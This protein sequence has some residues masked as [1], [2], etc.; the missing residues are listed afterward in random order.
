MKMAQL[1][2]EKPL[3]E[4]F[5]RLTTSHAELTGNGPLTAKKYRKGQTIF[6]QGSIPK[7]AHYIKSGW[8]KISRVDGNGNE[9]VLR[10]VTKNQFIGHLSLIKKWDYLSTAVAVTDCEIFF[11]AKQVFF[12]LLQKDNT[13][14]SLVI[15]M[16]AD[17]LVETETH[18]DTLLTK[19]IQERI[20][21][22][23]LSLEQS[24]DAD[25][26]FNDS[27]I[28]LPKKDLAAIVNITPETLSRHLK[29]LDDEGL[30]DNN[31]NHIELLNRNEL[32]K[33]SN[34]VD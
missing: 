26:T 8:V 3:K 31:K 34:L 1:K 25:P 15:E 33:K 12:E 28:R 10:L 19:N 18:L 17:E 29:M 2:N 9:K 20:A 27:L 32:L 24:S 7:G 16:L 13:F 21:N 5:E 23:L 14:A 4:L 6:Q 11:I 30:I 22:L